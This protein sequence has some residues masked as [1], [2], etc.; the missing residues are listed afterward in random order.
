MKSSSKAIAMLITGVKDRDLGLRQE[1]FKAFVQEM[2]AL[3]DSSADEKAGIYS[4]ENVTPFLLAFALEPDEELKKAM[5]AII[6][7]TG[8]L[9]WLKCFPDFNRLLGEVDSKES[10]FDDSDNK[11]MAK[12]IWGL[13]GFH[14][15]ARGF[16]GEDIFNR[17]RGEK[18]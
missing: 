6:K 17:I 15:L 10:E 9:S 4:A 16:F 8:M 5:G 2:L 14:D 12:G 11:A 18:K 1:G 13:Y 3:K 7:L